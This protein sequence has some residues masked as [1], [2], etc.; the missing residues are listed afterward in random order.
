MNE[1]NWMYMLN[2]AS[3][4]KQ[5]FRLLQ[6]MSDAKF[7][8]QHWP[9][10]PARWD[11]GVFQDRS[12]Q[13]RT[14]VPPNSTNKVPQP[15]QKSKAKFNCSGELRKARDTPGCSRT[16]HDTLGEGERVRP[17]KQSGIQVGRGSPEECNKK[18]WIWKGPASPEHTYA[19]HS[20]HHA[21]D[22]PTTET[23]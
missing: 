7:L 3:A 9:E 14:L 22:T 13:N 17:K 5:N 21:K 2:A 20:G 18:S 19:N 10:Q 23:S 12:Q 16:V 4:R 8:G 1:T 11:W 6:V 15:K